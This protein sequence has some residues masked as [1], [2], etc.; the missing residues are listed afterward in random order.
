MKTLW[1]RVSSWLLGLKVWVRERG[2]C[3]TGAVAVWED[4]Q[5]VKMDSGGGW[6]VGMC[7]LLLKIIKEEK[8]NEL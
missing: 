6:A 7:P 3:S 2:V 1:Q 8:A 5:V 4:E